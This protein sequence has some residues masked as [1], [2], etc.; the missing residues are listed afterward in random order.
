VARAVMEGSG[1]GV[2]RGGGGDRTAAG[3]RRGDTGS[4]GLRVAFG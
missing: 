1:L 2:L 4:S 3:P